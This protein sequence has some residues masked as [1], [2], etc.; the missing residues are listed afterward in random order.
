MTKG[1]TDL[2]LEVTAW[3]SG[4][5]SAQKKGSSELFGSLLPAG[6]LPQVLRQLTNLAYCR[7]IQPWQVAYAVT[8]VLCEVGV[9]ERITKSST[10]Q[11]SRTPLWLNVNAEP[12]IT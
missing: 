8:G 7:A 11:K 2:E 9:C 12:P 3:Q 4:R 6:T 10:E 1:D 5:M